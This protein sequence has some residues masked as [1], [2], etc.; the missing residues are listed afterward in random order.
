[1]GIKLNLGS[2]NRQRAQ[3]EGWVNIDRDAS[4]KPDIVRSLEVGLPFSDSVVDEVYASHVMEHV[5]NFFFLMQE[6]WRVCKSGAKIE[7]IVPAVY[8]PEGAFQ[9]DHVRYF[10]IESFD[11]FEEGF[12]GVQNYDQ[13][14]GESRFKILHKEVFSNWRPRAEIRFLLEVVKK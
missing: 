11:W 5:T 2:G 1:M 4:T 13:F 10:T 12:E 3:S 9:N 7:I 6:I 14:R 8:Y